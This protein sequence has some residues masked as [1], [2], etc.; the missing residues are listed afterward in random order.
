MSYALQSKQSKFTYEVPYNGGET[1]K[2]IS[3][4]DHKLN[5][6]FLDF[7]S[8]P[9]EKDVEY[10]RLLREIDKIYLKR[11]MHDKID[12][13]YDKLDLIY[14]S[15]N[16]DRR[17]IATLKSKIDKLFFENSSTD[18]SIEDENRLQLLNMKIDKLLHKDTELCSDKL[19]IAKILLNEREELFALIFIQ[20][21]LELNYKGYKETIQN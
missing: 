16:P 2:R 8:L 1:F 4:I 19:N 15:K 9:I 5:T 14:Q 12:K 10:N 13:I 11:D 20:S 17:E 21:S 7:H 3:E 6:I 18:L